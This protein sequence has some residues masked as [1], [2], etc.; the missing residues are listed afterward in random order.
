MLGPLSPTLV[1]GA[2]DLCAS[3]ALTFSVPHGWTILRL[4]TE[5]EPAPPS[6]ADLRALAAE[7]REA[8]SREVPPPQ[9]R[10]SSASRGISAGETVDT[11]G[12]VRSAGTTSA[13][14]TPDEDK[15]ARALREVGTGAGT[16]KVHTHH[17]EETHLPSLTVVP[18]PP[19]Q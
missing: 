9:L 7:I 10:S 4:I 11:A 19:N 3:H 18:D 17:E 14:T 16:H 8:A 6:E 13:L 5:F 2:L 1:P 12:T 15:V